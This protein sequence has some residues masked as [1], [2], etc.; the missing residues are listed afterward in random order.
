MWRVICLVG[1]LFLLILRAAPVFAETY[2]VRPNGSGDFPTLQAAIAAAEDGD[3][4]E[5]ADGTFS[6]H[7][8]RDLDFLAKAITIRSRS[9]SPADCRIDCGGSEIEAHRG[10]IA[11]SGEG[12]GS[13]LHGVTIQNGHHDL[14]G[15]VRCDAASPSI[16]NCRFVNNFAFGGGAIGF[17]GE[18]T[19]P[20][21]ADCAFVENEA[22]IGGAIY[23]SG[24]C[25]IERCEFSRNSAS[26]PDFGFAGAIAGDSGPATIRTSVFTENTAFGAGA[27]WFSNATVAIEECEFTE[28]TAEASG[29]GLVTE[30]GAVTVSGCLFSGNEAGEFGGAVMSYY[31]L[32]TVENC[33][34]EQNAAV[35]EGGGGGIFVEDSQQGSIVAECVFLANSAAAGGGLGLGGSL[36]VTGCTFCANTA[37][38]YGGGLMLTG[39]SQVD[40]CTILFNEAASGGGL[41][42]GGDEGDAHEVNRTLIVF[43][44]QG[45]GGAVACLTDAGLTLSCCDVFGNA[46]GDYVGCLDDSEGVKGNIRSNPQFCS[47]APQTDENWGLQDDSPCLPGNHPDEAQCGTIGALGLGCG[48]NPVVV[49]TWGRLKSRFRD[50]D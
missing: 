16:I 30:R 6:G 7:G 31:D 43:N 23:S 14:G 29:G 21:V 9:G 8:N 5:L 39:H 11:Q 18:S 17:A 38:Y 28:N 15:A 25:L 26:G 13:I 34:F 48:G 40:A 10:F 2:L 24:A 36:R 32:L 46:G 22:A 27:I 44:E 47:T 35:D 3:I 45:E 41:A 12:S 42:F 19:P 33:R 4:I 37:T 49:S 1:P 20:R 50:Q